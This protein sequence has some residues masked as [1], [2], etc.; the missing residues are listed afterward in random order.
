[1]KIK[2]A[3]KRTLNTTINR[4]KSERNDVYRRIVSTD[5]GFDCGADSISYGAN[6]RIATISNSEAIVEYV[7]TQDGLE[8]GYLLMLSN[9]VSFTRTVLRD[10]YRR[11]LVTSITN[12]VAF[13]VDGSISPDVSYYLDSPNGGLTNS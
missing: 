13:P 3:M 11:G 5:A 9:G 1:M 2:S 8:A 6:G 10:A 7:Y 12:V 4:S